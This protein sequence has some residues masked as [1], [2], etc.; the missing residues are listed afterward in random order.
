MNVMD[1][2]TAPVYQQLKEKGREKLAEMYTRC[3]RSTWDTTL[4]RADGTVFLV[5][6]DISAM[7][8]RDSSAQVYHYLPHAN[9]IP[10]VAD[11]IEQMLRR[12]FM[13]IS[14]DPYANAFN[15]EANGNKLHHDRTN[16]TAEQKEWIWERKYEIDSLYYPIRLAHGF[17]KETGNAAWCD[18]TFLKAVDAMP[19][20]MTPAPRVWASPSVRAL[21]TTVLTS[22]GPSLWL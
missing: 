2:M 9:E 21:P 13:Y 8:L 11:A 14:I 16:W 7:W 17:W 3:F 12:Q 6:G 1:R 5:T 15:K 19:P 10:E 20:P 4:Q 22:A 18:E